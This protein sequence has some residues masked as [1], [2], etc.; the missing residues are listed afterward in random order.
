MPATP[1]QDMLSL[2]MGELHTKE[3]VKLTHVLERSENTDQLDLPADLILAAL[4]PQLKKIRPIRS[5]S[6]MR[7]FCQPFEDILVNL[8]SDGVK[9]GRIERDILMP[10]WDLVSEEEEK[11]QQDRDQLDQ[12]IKH[13]EARQI[14]LAAHQFWQTCADILQDH[15]QAAASD[16][17]QAKDLRSRIGHQEAVEILADIAGM[18]QVADLIISLRDG[19]GPRPVRSLEEEHASLISNHIRRA[20]ERGQGLDYYLLLAAQGCLLHPAD[21]FPILK[22]LPEESDNASQ[23]ERAQ[24]GELVFNNLDLAADKLEDLVATGGD[25]QKLTAV[26]KTFAAELKNVAHVLEISTD[27]AWKDRMNNAMKRVGDVVC[28]QILEGSVNTVLQAYS[29]DGADDTPGEEEIAA[30]ERRI[31]AVCDCVLLA[32]PLAIKTQADRTHKESAPTIKR[33]V[34][35][36]HGWRSKGGR[37]YR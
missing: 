8:D 11:F 33:A 26:V 15:A 36:D 5:P 13:G 32:E 6:L 16:A 25:E 14:A 22:K 27:K 19:L 31:T 37:G 3:I 28:S 2:A 12:A 24:L 35:E 34:S 21:I 30:A 18:M 17:L 23:E 29:G 9:H 20:T 4:R 1:K 7:I 10:I